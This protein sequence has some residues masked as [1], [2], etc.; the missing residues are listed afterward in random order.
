MSV[1]TLYDA[2]APNTQVRTWCDDRLRV[3]ELGDSDDA[4]EPLASMPLPGY[5]TE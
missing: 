1:G 5:G 3:R 4:D 2:G